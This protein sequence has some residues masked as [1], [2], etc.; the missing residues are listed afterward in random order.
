MA[1]IAKTGSPSLSSLQPDPGVGKLPSLPCGEA[2]AA[3]DA[4]YIKSDGKIW[5]SIGTTL[6]TAAARVHGYAPMDCPVGEVLTLYHNVV[7]R[8]GAGLT[9]GAPYYLSLTVGAIGDAASTG[10]IGIIG[11]AIDA[12]RIMLKQGLY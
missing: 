10:G 1:D 7:F 2:I 3:G 5:R 6:A 11:F 8:Y 12:T 9:P 4:C